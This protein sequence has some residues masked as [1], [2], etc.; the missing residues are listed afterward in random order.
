MKKKKLIII[1]VVVLLLVV[2][3]VVAYMFLFAGNDE[4]ESKEPETYEFE[5]G[6]RMGNLAP[7]ENS[8]KAPIIKYNAVIVYIE[9]GTSK[10]LNKQKTLIGNE[11]SKYFVTK[12]IPQIRRQERVQ[13]DLADIVREIMGEDGELIQDVLFKDITWQ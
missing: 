6:E 5:L 13:E 10:E 1:I 2:V 12:T 9:E 7:E 3:G 11:F 8:K 4:E